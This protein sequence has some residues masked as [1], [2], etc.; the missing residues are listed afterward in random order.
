MGL[1]GTR[2]T[3]DPSSWDE[4]WEV[5]APLGGSLAPEAVARWED[6]VVTS[7]PAFLEAA[8][9]QLG[10]AYRLL[11][12]EA[13]AREIGPGAF[14]GTDRPFAA[15]RFARVVDTVVVGGQDA[16]VR[17]AAD[18]AAV[19]SFAATV[20]L[21]DPLS[22]ILDEEV[23]LAVGLWRVHDRARF[24]RGAELRAPRT[25]K[26]LV[27]SPTVLGRDALRAWPSLQ[28]RT[29]NRAFAGIRDPEVPWL[30]VDALTLDEALAASGDRGAV[31]PARDLLDE[32]GG[33]SWAGSVAAGR[34][35]E[36]LGTDA[37]RPDGRSGSIS[38]IRLTLEVS[39]DGPDGE[40]R[41]ADFAPDQWGEVLEVPVVLDPDDA[42][43]DGA[44][45][46]AAVLVL[47]CARRLL[48]VPLVATPQN[49][50]A[51]TRL[52]GR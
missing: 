24:E 47:A 34:L 23:P 38:L 40:S 2:R 19:R 4:L 33:W 3:A 25:A 16:V 42:R 20:P 17:V 31:A 18:P 49:L 21:L 48:D 6:V 8:S 35:F 26:R 22:A 30:E 7:P 39:E 28:G 46:R 14:A 29:P 1:F 9:E 5:L 12:T 37:L 36:G 27:L 41:P 11:G 15:R 44:E 13:H 50:P 45:A 10:H 32:T 51:L 43:V 52:A